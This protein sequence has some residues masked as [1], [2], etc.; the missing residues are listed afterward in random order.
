[1]KNLNQKAQLSLLLAVS[2]LPFA[3]ISAAGL[4]GTT[5][6]SD[7]S[8]TVNTSGN[9]NT[10]TTSSAGS[11]TDSSGSVNTSVK[12]TG[13]ST[14]AH[15]EDANTQADIDS[16]NDSDVEIDLDQDSSEV[17]ENASTRILPFNVRTH[18]DLKAFASAE[19]REDENLT[20][21]NFDKDSL[22]VGY[23]EEGRFLALIP[24]KFNV[25]AIVA[26]DGKVLVHYPWYKFLVMSNKVDVQTA[27]QSEVSAYLGTSSPRT[28]TPAIQAELAARIRAI[29]ASHLTNAGATASSTTSGSLRN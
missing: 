26:S 7:N 20:S 27:I 16:E 23:K 6:Y 5:L 24:M 17:R 25:R 19:L 13:S 8:A 18:S 21:L 14:V 15:D 3:S 9:I 2:L 1:M 22:E 12:L 4:I 11:N 29:F 28:F 10:V